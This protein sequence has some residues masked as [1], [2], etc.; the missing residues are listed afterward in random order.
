MEI[1]IK[2]EWNYKLTL[3]IPTF[4]RCSIKKKNI[5]S[6]GSGLG[7]KFGT[8][9]LSRGRCLRWSRM[10]SKRHLRVIGVLRSAREEVPGKE[11]GRAERQR[12]LLDNKVQ[13]E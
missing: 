11:A 1:Q 5:L 3:L 7:G 10:D 8:C 12:E 13:A 9:G 4:S 2:A 6:K